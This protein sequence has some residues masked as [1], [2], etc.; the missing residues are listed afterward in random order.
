MG[1]YQ[2]YMSSKITIGKFVFN[3]RVNDVEINTSRKN[4]TQTATI[5]LP[6]YVRL[7]GEP[8]KLE[9][10]IK[11]GDAV[12]IALGYDDNLVQ[13]FTGYVVRI[14]PNE[15]L[16]LMCEDEMWKYK[17]STV[18][19]SWAQIQLKA[20][21]QELFPQ[22]TINCPDVLLKPFRLDGVTKARALEVLKDEYL[23]SS[24][25]RNGKLVLGFAYYETGL[26][27]VIYDFQKNA[28]GDSLEFTRKEDVKIKV[29]AISIQ[30]DNTRHE[31]EY[32]DND[33]DTITLNFYNKTTSELTALAKE[34]INQLKYDGYKGSLTGFGV[35][36]AQHGMTAELRDSRYPERAGSYFIDGV[37]IMYNSAGFRREVQ[38]GRTSTANYVD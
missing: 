19:K 10:L 31:I 9:K 25:F 5:K 32:G 18:T 17:Q 36:Y 6:N 14:K 35:P 24:Y 15:T 37:K 11:V 21:L 1:T 23:L 16:D 12:T 28:I 33:G 7:T 22:A 38:L 13:E 20:L 30:P 4:S 3:S 34:K 2:V 8:T 29:K 26:G 27:N